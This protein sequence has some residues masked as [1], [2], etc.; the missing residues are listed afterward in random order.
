MNYSIALVPYLGE[1]GNY[2]IGKYQL[3]NFEEFKNEIILDEVVRTRATELAERHREF[4]ID[5]PVVDVC[6]K[7]IMAITPLNYCE[8]NYTYT[9]EDTMNM[10][11][12]MYALAFYNIVMNG[13]TF[14][15]SDL[16]NFS[17]YNFTGES[18]GMIVHGRAYTNME[19]VKFIKPYEITPWSYKSLDNFFIK[20]IGMSL[21]INNRRINSIFRT[22]ELYYH[23]AAMGKLVSNE[24]RI[25]NLMMA[26]D[27]ILNVKNKNDFAS[28]IE[29]FFVN[30]T[31]K[32]E[33][34]D[35]SI[36]YQRIEKEWN[37][38][39]WWCYDLYKLR[40]DIIHCN[41]IDWKIGRYGHIFDYVK[42]GGK[43]L[44]HLIYKVLEDENIMGEL[45]MD[46]RI[47]ILFDLESKLDEELLKIQRELEED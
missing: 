43:L 13:N 47:V 17:I 8:E 20:S 21:G 10:R 11:N 32:K 35:I 37:I 28:K 16:Y 19:Y 3:W 23:A 22:L 27:T 33:T 25:L 30:M 26:F 31:Y 45:S 7:N 5:I 24:S 2:I 46:Q 4:V 6:C 39:S 44:M 34:R 14:V 38:V 42:F 12:I 36:N 9:A 1:Q 41:E 18:R 15:T 29:K 40:N